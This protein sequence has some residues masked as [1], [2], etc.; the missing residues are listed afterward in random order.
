MLEKLKEVI[1]RVMPEINVD[2][3]TNDTKLVDDLEF[4]SIGIMML[5]MTL[6]EEFGV[7]FDGPISFITVGDVV[8]FLEEHK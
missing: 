3:V 2:N 7:T 5:A 1:K 8:K 6:E 4:D